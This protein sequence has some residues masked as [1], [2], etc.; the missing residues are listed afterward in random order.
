[1]TLVAISQRVDYIADRHEHRDSLDQNLGLWLLTNNFLPVQI[2]NILHKSENTLLLESWLKSVSPD[3]LIL[4]GGNDLGEYPKRDHTEHELLEWARINKVPVLGICRGMQ[5]M[6]VLSGSTLKPISGHVRT[7][8][9]IRGKLNRVVNS[10]H[11]Y[12]LDHC[13]ADFEI[14]ALSE[15]GEIEAIRHKSLPWEGWMW[16]PERDIEFNEQDNLRLRALFDNA[17]GDKK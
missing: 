16:H 4:S 14:L 8:H 2:P 6:G 9:S 5:S 13:P 15:D 12:S 10:F 3:A 1:M 17:N 11:N 7:H